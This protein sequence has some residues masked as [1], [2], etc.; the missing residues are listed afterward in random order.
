MLDGEINAGSNMQVDESGCKCVK[1]PT[2]CFNNTEMCD[3]TLQ[4]N[5]NS[6]T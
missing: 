4:R 6:T 2:I 5:T 3:K 1:L